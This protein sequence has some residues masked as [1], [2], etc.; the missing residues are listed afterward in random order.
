[1]KKD[2]ESLERLLNH[3]ASLHV[4]Q[5]EV[6]SGLVSQELERRTKTLNGLVSSLELDP[7]LIANFD[8]PKIEATSVEEF[9]GEAYYRFFPKEKPTGPE[10]LR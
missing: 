8:L 6:V 1:M 5:K 4:N 7:E 2:L 3:I 9:V 10:R